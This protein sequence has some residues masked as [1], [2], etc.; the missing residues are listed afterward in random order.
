VQ[1]FGL[2]ALSAPSFAALFY[3]RN[4]HWKPVAISIIRINLL[5]I[6]LLALDAE[7]KNFLT[8]F[9]AMIADDTDRDP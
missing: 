8:D 7:T 6:S 5:L 4:E 9:P 3:L 1:A 2:L